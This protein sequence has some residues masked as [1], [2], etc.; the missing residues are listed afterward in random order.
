MSC[1]V[2]LATDANCESSIATKPA[3]IINANMIDAIGGRK[4]PIT[5]ALV[6][7][8]MLPGMSNPDPAAKKPNSPIQIGITMNTKE[9]ITYAG[10]IEPI[11]IENAL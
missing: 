4:V 5:I 6:V 3:N 11:L 2:I 1:P 7:P 10:I 9:A 8:T